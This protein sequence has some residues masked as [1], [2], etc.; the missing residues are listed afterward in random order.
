MGREARL[1][2]LLGQAAVAGLQEDVGDM[3]LPSQSL[4][5]DGTC[6][7]V[8]LFLPHIYV[9]VAWA[10]SDLNTLIFLYRGSTWL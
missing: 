5:G 8:L 7:P 4:M 3:I 9:G 10:S 6:Q 1:I 2:T